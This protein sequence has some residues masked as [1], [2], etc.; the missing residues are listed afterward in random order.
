VDTS[1]VTV[2][3]QVEMIIEQVRQAAKRDGIELNNL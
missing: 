1:Y 3:Q 2:Q